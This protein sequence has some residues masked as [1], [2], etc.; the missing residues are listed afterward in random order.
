MRQRTSDASDI[1][2]PSTGY[3][4]GPPMAIVLTV[5]VRSLQSHWLCT[6]PTVINSFPV[7]TISCEMLIYGDELT[8]G[9]LSLP[10]SPFV[11]KTSFYLVQL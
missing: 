7:A 5:C 6:L 10:M 2:L 9:H 11:S 1:S 8:P 3:V 4:P